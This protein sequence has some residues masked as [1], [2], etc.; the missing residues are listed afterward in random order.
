M[1]Y[2]K[3]YLFYIITKHQATLAAYVLT[4]KIIII[5]FKSTDYMVY[6]Q[7]IQI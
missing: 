1:Y 6:L 3:I 2:F 7:A 5:L 4:D